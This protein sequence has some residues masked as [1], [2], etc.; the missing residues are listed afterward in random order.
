MILNPICDTL[1]EVEEKAIPSDFGQMSEYE[2]ID[3]DYAI[4]CH[5]DILYEQSGPNN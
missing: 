4:E 3:Y 5:G 2:N 1:N